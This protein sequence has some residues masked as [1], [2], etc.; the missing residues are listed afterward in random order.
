M[1]VLHDAVSV[2][3]HIPEVHVEG[4]VHRISNGCGHRKERRIVETPRFEES[5]KIV[6]PTLE[7]LRVLAPNIALASVV[8]V[9]CFPNMAPINKIHKQERCSDATSGRI[10]CPQRGLAV[11]MLRSALSET[12]AEKVIINMQCIETPDIRRNVLV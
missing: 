12:R 2:N 4:E 9:H 6:S 1:I 10:V 11:L 5:W 7:R 8:Y 3:P